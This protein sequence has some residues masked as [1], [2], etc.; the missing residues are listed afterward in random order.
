[1]HPQVLRELAEVVAWPLSIIFQKP[2]RTGEVPNGW[3][4]AKINSCLQK[5]QEGESGKLPASQP[6]FHP[7]KGDGTAHFEDHQAPEGK[8]GYW[9]WS[10]WIHQE[11][12]LLD[13]SDAFYDGTAGWVDERRAVGGVYLDFSKVF[14]TVSHN[15]P[16]DKLRKCELDE[17]TVRWVKNWLHG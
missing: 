6:H 9:E 11:E 1:M 5:G 14:D 17:W 12:I 16:M 3:R 8:Q 10:A 2:W 15:I 13:Q 4:K 7:W